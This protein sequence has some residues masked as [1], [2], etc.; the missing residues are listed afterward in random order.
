MSSGVLERAIIAPAHHLSTRARRP[1]RRFVCRAK[2][3]GDNAKR[4]INGVIVE[5]AQN[6]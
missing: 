1:A 5:I 2:S 3:P 4:S 6:W